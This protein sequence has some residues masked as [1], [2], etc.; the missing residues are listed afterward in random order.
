M[1]SKYPV[2]W[3]SHGGDTKWI[4]RMTD[5][6]LCAAFRKLKA[7]LDAGKTSAN[8]KALDH[9][10]AEMDAR[11]LDPRWKGGKPPANDPPPEGDVPGMEE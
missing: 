8:D 7:A 11:G 3:T 5:F 1:P 10:Y 6:H 9:L 2:E 4:E